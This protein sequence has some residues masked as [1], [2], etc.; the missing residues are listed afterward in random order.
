M[1][2]SRLSCKVSTISNSFRDGEAETS[3]VA[4]TVKNL[5]AMQENQVWSLGREDPPG[6]GNSDPLQ[7]PCLESSLE[8][9]PGGLQFMGLQRVQHPW[10]TH[11]L[12]LKHFNVLTGSRV[13]LKSNQLTPEPCPLY[14]TVRQTNKNL[15]RIVKAGEE[16]INWFHVSFGYD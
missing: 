5:P 7:Y 15:G 13:R 8:E 2:I 1:F 10:V 9:E 12:R 3:L 11:K 6:E 16:K 14:Y 4:Q